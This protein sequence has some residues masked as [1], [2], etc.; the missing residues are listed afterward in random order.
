VPFKS[1][2][3]A[4]LTEP[5][6]VGELL[7]AIDGYSGQVTTLCGLQLAALLFL[8]PGEL[9]AG[10]W[11]EVDLEGAAP[12]WRIPAHRNPGQPR[13]AQK[14]SNGRGALSRA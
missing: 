3:H 14:L 12:T 8:R 7:R 4:A 2:N 9:R 5:N 13:T 10:Q 6:R 11:S 1:R